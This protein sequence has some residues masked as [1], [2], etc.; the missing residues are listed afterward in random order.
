M[1]LPQPNVTIDG[2]CSVIYD[3]TLYSYSSAALQSLA[4]VEGATWKTLASGQSVQGGVCVGSTPNNS[5]QAGLYVVGGTTSDADYRGLQKFTYS[6][7][8]WESIIPQVTVTQSRIWHSA[9]YINGSDTILVYAGSQDGIKYPST[10]TFTIGAS[11]PYPV[12]A[13]DSQAPPG[14]APILLPWSETEAVLVGGDPTNTKIMLFDPA[15]SWFDSNSSLAAPLTKDTSQVKAA[16]ISGDDGSKH[17]Y[18]FDLSTAPNTVNRTMLIDGNGSP[19]VNAVPVQGS[20]GASS[21]RDLDADNWPTYN[22]SL[23][24]E[25]TRTQYS[26]ASDSDGMVIMSGGNQNDVLCVFDAK[27]NCWQNAT[28]LLVGKTVGSESTPKSTSTLLSSTSTPAAS[29][30]E[31]PSTAASLI[32]TGLAPTAILGIALGVIF[33]CALLLIGLLFLIKRKRQRQAYV[34]TG[35][36]RRQSGIPEEKNYPPN[37]VA[38]ASGGFFPGH[39]QQDSQNSFSSM[40]ILM[41]KGQKPTLNRKPSKDSRRSSTSS[42][43]NKQFKNTIGRPSP[44]LEPEIEPR[45]LPAHNVPADEKAVAFAAATN[46]PK[47]RTGPVPTGED[48]TRRS[49]GWNRYWSGGSNLMG[50]GGGG[51]RRETQASEQSSHYSD[52]H[53]MT[54]D[55]ATVPPLHVEGRPSFNRV[56]SGSPTVS[57]YAS[58]PR[59]GQSAEIERPVSKASSSGY[60]SGIPPSIH[61]SWDPTTAQKAWG[62]DRAPSSAYNQSGYATVL[63]APESTSS[64]PNGVS[65]QP[66]L[67]MASTSSDMSWLNLGENGKSRQ[68]R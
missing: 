12:L 19:V 43:V 37:E 60:S 45:D 34:E 44:I 61:E 28:A 67:A 63:G 15:K 13:F 50:F 47:P 32:S 38:Q 51:S 49:S 40:A 30:T 10:Q 66:Q 59:V 9:T 21:K 62:E 39:T 56:H 3:N 33:G 42:I 20:K 26:L 64:P 4:L 27:Q 53:R 1:P 65:R 55:S 29:A 7:G 31:R 54:Q 58:Y 16:I 11:E 35:H 5:S 24:P 6:T 23:A 41:G 68:Y 17:L 57:Y 14:I 2:A 36:A 48:G 8:K 46:E 22:S 25:V 18:T 52:V